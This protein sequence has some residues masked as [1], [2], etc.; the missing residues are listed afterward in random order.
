[1]KQDDFGVFAEYYDLFYLG[2][3]DYEKE[4]KILKDTI[5]KL[6][7]KKS[8][9]LLDVGC[10]TG[11]HLKYLSSDFDCTGLDINRR[12]IQ[13]AKS[14]V[15]EAEFK[16]ANMMDFGFRSKFDVVICLFSSIGYVQS[17]HNLVKTLE[18]FSGHLNDTGLVV[19]EPW[20]FKKDFKK[21]HISLDT[22]EE[23]G[24]KFVRMAK[25]RIS[26]STWFI[27]MHYL[28]GKNEEI[29]HFSEI[30]KMLALDYQEYVEAFRSSGFKGTRYVTENLWDGCRGL[31]TATK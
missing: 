7:S 22:I 25:S 16:V 8:G 24:L 5:E 14:K 31:F 6:G 15:P 21:G 29:K 9:T 13:I 10:G 19:V 11:E 3:K 23:D 2:K 4:A 18:N 27:Y 28:V 26:G 17:F 30:H 12:M 1:M 20:V